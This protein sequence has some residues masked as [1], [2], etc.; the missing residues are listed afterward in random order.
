MALIF[1][2]LTISAYAQAQS[3]HSLRMVDGALDNFE[4]LL[5]TPTMVF[6][7]NAVPLGKN[8]FRLETDI[9]IFTD[10]VNA[11]QIGA[12]LND[13]ENIGT[14]YNGK[15]SKLTAKVTNIAPTGEKTADFVMISIAGPIQIKTEYTALVKTIT[16][17]DAKTAIEVRQ[18]PND[19]ETN[20]ELKNL[21]ATRYVEDVTINGKIYTYLRL[22][23]LDDINASILPGAKGFLEKNSSPINDEIVRLIISAAKKK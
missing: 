18:A 2:C 8:W 23:T 1:T 10:E 4:S 3:V 13:L 17:T 6:S 12:V 19:I 21:L 9:H 11:K 15:R 5:N 14:Y 7:P 20:K 16:H 22:Y